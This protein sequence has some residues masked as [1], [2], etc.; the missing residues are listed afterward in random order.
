MFVRIRLRGTLRIELVI[1]N[2]HAF[3]IEMT[4][5]VWGFLPCIIW[6]DVFGVTKG[7]RGLLWRCVSGCMSAAMAQYIRAFRF[8]VA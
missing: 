1:F 4:E 7:K 5:G 8:Y 6:D 3:L 2:G